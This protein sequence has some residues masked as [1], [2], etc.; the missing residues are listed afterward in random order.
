[1]GSPHV[2][3]CQ[4]RSY[5]TCG[6]DEAE[7]SLVE[8]HLQECQ[9]CCET[10][11]SRRETNSMTEL[12]QELHPANL[13]L[14]QNL[15]AAESF[16]TSEDR[17]EIVEE[18]GRG[19]SCAVHKAFDR[20]LKRTVALKFSLLADPTARERNRFRF[21]AETVAKLKHSY[22]AQIY[23]FIEFNGKPC[24]VLEFVEGGSLDKYVDRF[25]W[26]IQEI[27]FLVQS[28]SQAMAYAHDK[29]VLHR[30]LKPANILLSP[31]ISNS[32]SGNEF[33]PKL[34]DFG[35]AKWLNEN[36]SLTLTGTILGTPGY[37]S[38]EQSF[39]QSP[40]VTTD[41]YSIGVILYEL[42]TERLP[43]EGSIAEVVKKVAEQCPIA[44]RKLNPNVPV[45]L[46]R[47]C[48][49]CLQKSPRNR[50]ESAVELS[51]DLGRFLEDKPVVALP[52]SVART[53]G[54]LISRNPIASALADGMHT[55]IC[56]SNCC[57]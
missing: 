7:S 36:Q 10:I 31:L 24:L 33:R 30:D 12:F 23:E 27:A 48:L 6:L 13:R 35:I 9:S 22:I 49:K 43:F 26:T 1:M 16:A 46:E 57:V 54:S 4:L 41:V 5:I 39:G 11:E 18:I 47:V 32:E 51:D 20:L 19:G 8:L 2:E 29:G 28:I 37:M 42:L 44:P 14:G 52:P 53:A 55:P 38:P 56:P 17:F 3:K 50:Y 34:A 45:D 15:S 21:E 25:A 40:D